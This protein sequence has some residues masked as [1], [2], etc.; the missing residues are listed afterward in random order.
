MSIFDSLSA[1]C[2]ECGTAQTIKVVASIN[3]DRRP[4]LR[5]QIID[6]TFQTH[7][8]QSCAITFRLPPR[9]TYQHFAE[10]LWLIAH[11]RRDLAKWQELEAEAL[12]VFD[13]VYGPDTPPLSRDIGAQLTPRLAFG[14]PAVRE[15]IL[16][17]GAGLDD[18]ALELLKMAVIHQVPKSPV[19]D[20]NELRLERIEGA[21]L[22]LGWIEGPTEAPI[23]SL[24]VPRS[25]YDEIVADTAG[26]AEPRAQ[27]TGHPFVD[28]NR[29]L[30]PAA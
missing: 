23:T 3:A 20:D 29:L 26:W 18:V 30:V 28:L 24:K 2:P 15:K 22:V 17:R 6:G 10:H 11:P 27:L 8:C 9:F 21:T 1:I 25:A 16:A 12:E 4:D 19:S 13:T 5:Q 14:W 7:T